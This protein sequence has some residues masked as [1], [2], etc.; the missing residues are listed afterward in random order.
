MWGGERRCKGLRKPFCLRKVIK[1]LGFEKQPRFQNNTLTEH[2]P[3]GQ[4]DAYTS[5]KKHKTL[6]VW[7]YSVLSKKR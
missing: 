1:T 6:K 2:S 4:E 7:Y 5:R 3:M